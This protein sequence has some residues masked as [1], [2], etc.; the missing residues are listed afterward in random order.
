MSLNLADVI[1]LSCSAGIFKLTCCKM[2][3]NGPF[4][5]RRPTGFYRP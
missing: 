4:E 2:L 5:G 1:S 3:R